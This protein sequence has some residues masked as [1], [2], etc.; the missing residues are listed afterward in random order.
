MSLTHRS[1]IYLLVCGLSILFS[2]LI[3]TLHFFPHLGFSITF[4]IF[5]TFAY[6]F[7]KEKSKDTKLYLSLSLMFSVLLFIRSEPLITFLN[8][9]STLFFGLLMLI[10][11]LKNSSGFIDYV[12]APVKFVLKTFLSKKSDYVLEFKQDKKIAT[13]VK[14]V[15]IVFGILVT[16]LLLAVVLPLLSSAN[17]FFNNI[18]ENI[19]K[20]ISLENLLKNIG[21]DVVFIS[22]VRLIL[23]LVFIFMIPKAL[24]LINKSLDYKIPFSTSSEVLP[25]SIPK[26]ALTLVLFVFFITQFQFYFVG[27]TELAKIGLTHSQRT[28]EVFGQ[29]TLVAAIILLLI[30]NARNKGLYTKTINWT[31]GVQGIF[32]TFMAYKSVFEYIS[33]WGLTYKRLYGL[34]FATWILGIFI[35]LFIN[36]KKGQLVSLFVKKTIIFTGVLLVLINVINFDY[37][38]F[39]FAKA[40]TGQGIDYTYLSQLSADSLSYGEQYKKLENI[41]LQGKYLLDDYDN[42]NPMI[43]LYK[44]ENLQ[45]KYKKFDLRT[46]NLLDFLQ[47]QG[48]ESVDTTYLRDYYTS[49]LFTRTY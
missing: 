29:L 36:Y 13:A 25:L 17:P 21:F 11:D 20:F 47:Y 26:I 38:I 24:T 48:I 46:L 39:H 7:K 22:I 34:S 16:V 8:L 30:H 12:Y 2:Y 37:Q 27:D 44:I 32:L 28:R 49:K 5:L 14:I 3:T 15:E 33:A 9:L 1:K 41:T 10:S 43:I 42:E 45:D 40:T 31:L 35:L 4:F 19:L 6:K 23:F 18:V